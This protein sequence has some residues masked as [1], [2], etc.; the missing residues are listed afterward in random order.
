MG[1]VAAFSP[2]FKMYWTRYVDCY[3][4]PWCYKLTLFEKQGEHRALTDV[5]HHGCVGR[6][7]KVLPPDL[8]LVLH[9]VFALRRGAGCERPV[10]VAIAFNRES[11]IIFIIL[12]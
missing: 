9:S 4:E 7:L 10:T 1:L 5:S 2:E 12:L 3:F 11:H 8:A 6:V